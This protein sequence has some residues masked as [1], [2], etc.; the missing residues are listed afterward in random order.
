MATDKSKTVVFIHGAW[1]TPA[2][3]DDFRKPYEA[4]GYAVHAPAWPFIAGDAAELRLHPPA[5]L[6][7]LTV[8]TI[9]DHY[10]RFIETLPA[11]PV[12][13]GHSFGGLFAQILLDRGLGSMGVAIDPGPIAGVVPGPL[14]LA[15]ALPIIL[16]WN[17]WNRPFTLTR[18]AFAK[19]FA[20]AAPPEIQK[21]AYDRL[22]V[23][24]SGRIFYQAASWIGTAVRPSRRKQPLLIMVGEKDRTVT[25]YVARAAYRIQK[26]SSARTDFKLIPGHS[27]F[28]IGEPGWDD[29]AR[30][31][32]A[33]IE[34]A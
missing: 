13:V 4:A 16:R 11:P 21:T 29:V 17:G 23:P 10:A 7:G 9:V 1:M 14:S 33:W 26:L 25:P 6:G 8:G 18:E 30:A 12:L 32:L 24:T 31:A 19:S 3:W 20:N 22:V 28:L 34:E 27:H 5:G 2:C 15:A